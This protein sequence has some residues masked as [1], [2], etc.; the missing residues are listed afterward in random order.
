[1]ADALTLDGLVYKATVAHGDDGG[2]SFDIA[3]NFNGA[4]MDP[5]LVVASLRALADRIKQMKTE[6][7]GLV[8]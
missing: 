1:M 8:N 7:R 6:S 4:D 2:I 3:G 5:T